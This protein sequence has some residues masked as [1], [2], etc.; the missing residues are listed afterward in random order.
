MAF[1]K[2]IFLVSKASGAKN[3]KMVNERLNASLKR[4]NT[5][6]LDLYYGVHGL[7][8][9]KKLTPELKA[10]AE[11]MKKEGKIR[12]FGFSAHQNMEKCI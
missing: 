1:G 10:W 12:Y 6:Y 3:I 5:D 8:N 7:S 2:D 11:K 4:L 9:P